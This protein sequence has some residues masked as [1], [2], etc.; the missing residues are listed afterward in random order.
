MEFRF[1]PEEEAWR[2]EVRSFLEREIT[3]QV[4]EELRQKGFSK[5]FHL[6]LA[7]AGILAAALPKEYGGRGYG[8]L[9]QFIFNDE[10][11]RAK[12]P[13]AGCSAIGNSVHVLGGMLISYGTEEQKRRWVPPI[14]RGELISSQGLTEPNAGSDLASVEL[15][16]VE[17]GDHYILNGTKLYSNALYAT[18]M[19]AVT[20]TDPTVRK[21]QGIS[22]FVVDL[23]SPG[24]SITPV[25]SIGGDRRAEVSFS[26]VRVPK[27]NLIGQ[28]NRGWYHLVAGGGMMLER[29]QP[30]TWYRTKYALEEF[31]DFVKHARREGQPLSKVPAVR[32]ALAELAAEAKIG[33]L[34]NYHAACMMER[35]MDVLDREVPMA[36]LYL[37]E[38]MERFANTA[39]D[40]LGQYGQLESW[41]LEQRWVPLKGDLAME[42][43]NSREQQVG[44]GT[45]EIQ[46]NIIAM[47]G[48]GL[49]KSR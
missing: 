43:R 15:R 37:S 24:V 13:F 3:P 30:T 5:Q 41:G 22:L 11:A 39:L 12:M 35:R 36:K 4:R 33:W 17:D 19:F 21:Y 1:S 29:T 2:E 44:G 34:L 14:V 38:L 46:K 27:F 10:L 49:P 48:L 7:Q 20:R 31:I 42:Y 16:A 32:Y 18:H 26:D 25:I 47:R 23:S 45:S 40:I 6:K 9:K 28:K 8:P